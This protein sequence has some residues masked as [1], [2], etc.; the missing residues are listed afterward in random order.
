[1]KMKLVLSPV[2]P[3]HQW[4]SLNTAS[5]LL[6]YHSKHT[7]TLVDISTNF[8]P[9]EYGRC[10]G[11]CD[12]DID[13]EGELVCFFPNDQ[14]RIVPGCKGRPSSGWEYCADPKDIEDHAKQ[15]GVDITEVKAALPSD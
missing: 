6:I 10:Q 8:G 11:D 2:V 9:G 5:T 14:I 1:M 3:E 7:D 4:T 15:F 12:E 13:C